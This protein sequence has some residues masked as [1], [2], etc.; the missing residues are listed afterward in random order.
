M[1][2]NSSMKEI[3]VSHDG[4]VHKIQ[5]ITPFDLRLVT[6]NVK[7]KYSPYKIST[8]I[9]NMYETES[10]A[11]SQKGILFSTTSFHER[12]ALL[13]IWIEIPNYWAIKSQHVDYRHTEAP[14]HF[15]ILSRVLNCEEKL[16][17]SAQYQILCEN[18][19]IDAIDGLVLQDYLISS[20][21]VN[22]K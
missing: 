11:L 22:H 20:S 13:R 5:E 17:Q 15:Q 7:I 1:G 10:L 14:T 9:K 18:L 16:N 12:G 8:Q 3:S 6:K 19:N 21:G 2:K 4:V